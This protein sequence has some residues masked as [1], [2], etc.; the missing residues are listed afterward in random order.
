MRRI[1][2]VRAGY[3]NDFYGKN[4]LSYQMALSGCHRLMRRLGMLDGW[5][6]TA[7]AVLDDLTNGMITSQLKPR[8]RVE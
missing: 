7:A 5:A 4:E 8:P 1:G 2:L 6:F 3:L